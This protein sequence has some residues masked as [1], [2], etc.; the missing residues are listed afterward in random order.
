MPL[1]GSNGETHSPNPWLRTSCL[2]SV[3]PLTPPAATSA[4]WSSPAPPA[5]TRAAQGEVGGLGCQAAQGAGKTSSLSGG[6]EQPFEMEVQF[7]DGAGEGG[8]VLDCLARQ[9]LG[10]PSGAQGLMSTR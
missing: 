3:Y 10:V 2:H 4:W 8:S 5:S 6:E 7:G 9:A 1:P